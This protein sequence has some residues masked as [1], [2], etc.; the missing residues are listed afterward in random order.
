M[1]IFC[2]FNGKNTCFIFILSNYVIYSFNSTISQA[3][4]WRW[5]V[6][7]KNAIVLAFTEHSASNSGMIELA[8]VNNS[9]SMRFFQLGNF[10]EY[11][12]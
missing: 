3:L 10:S 2:F 7:S 6:Y 11:L 4:C 9:I 8:F 12:V 1:D 5:G